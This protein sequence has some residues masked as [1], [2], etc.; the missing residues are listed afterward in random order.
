MTDRWKALYSTPGIWEAGLRGLHVLSNWWIFLILHIYSPLISF[1]VYLCKCL[2][3]LLYWFHLR[4]AAQQLITLIILRIYGCVCMCVQYTCLRA[5]T[6]SDF[7]H[8]VIE[9]RSI[10][11]ADIITIS[12]LIYRT[13]ITISISKN[14]CMPVFYVFCCFHF[15]TLLLPMFVIMQWD[16]VCTRKKTETPPEIFCKLEKRKYT[17]QYLFPCK[18]IEYS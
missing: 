5:V 16:F 11:D 18:I 13:I 4:F 3:H 2:H 15:Q 17:T 8:A 9:A 6:I 7:H 10:R 1:F 14:K 12:I